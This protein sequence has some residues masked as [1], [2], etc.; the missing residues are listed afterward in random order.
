MA[1]AIGPGDL[2]E[3]VVSCDERSPDVAPHWLCGAEIVAGRIYTVMIVKTG[4]DNYGVENFGYVLT[5]KNT[6][7]PDQWGDLGGWSHEF[8]R[9][10]GRPAADF[11]ESL[12]APSPSRELEDA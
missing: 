10:L 8:F 6:H 2:V 9:P 11:I 12:K 4:A 3:C 1:G 7:W 5:D